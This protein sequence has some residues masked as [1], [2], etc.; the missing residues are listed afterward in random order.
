MGE[1]IYI[2]LPPE[3]KRQVCRGELSSSVILHEALTRCFS[4]LGN[5]APLGAHVTRGRDGGLAGSQEE[6][7]EADPNA[8]IQ[9]HVAEQADGQSGRRTGEPLPRPGGP[10]GQAGDTRP[11]LDPVLDPGDNAQGAVAP[12]AQAAG[13]ETQVS[14]PDAAPELEPGDGAEAE[15]QADAERREAAARGREGTTSAQPELEARG[16]DGGRRTH[17]AS[18]ALG[19]DVALVALGAGFAL[20]ASDAVLAVAARTTL[21]AAQVAGLEAPDLRSLA[22]RNADALHPVPLALPCGR[23]SGLR[24]AAIHVALGDLSAI[25]AGGV[26]GATHSDPLP[27]PAG[28]PNGVMVGGDLPLVP[29]P[30]QLVAGAA[31]GR[32]GGLDL[33]RGG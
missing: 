30:D 33:E 17:R 24:T 32:D 3:R 8:R 29:R 11:E 25:V 31:V 5:D 16:G 9:P 28:A 2:R 23:R 6:A 18:G 20:R 7:A 14:H 13:L 1:R 21:G 4:D 10:M 12:G 27:L 22:A 19:A 15:S 26:R